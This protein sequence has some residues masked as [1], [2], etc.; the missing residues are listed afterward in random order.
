[1]LLNNIKENNRLRPPIL[2]ENNPRYCSACIIVNRYK[3]VPK[4]KPAL[5]SNMVKSEAINFLFSL[6]LLAILIKKNNRYKIVIYTK[7][8]M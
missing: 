5:L 6:M 1:L 4:Y 3:P 2:A 7:L 8:T